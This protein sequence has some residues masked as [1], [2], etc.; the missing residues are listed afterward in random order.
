MSAFLDLFYNRSSCKANFHNSL[1]KALTMT[2]FV[3]I[4]KAFILVIVAIDSLTLT[5]DN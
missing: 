5:L 3:S 4:D 2:T 1:S